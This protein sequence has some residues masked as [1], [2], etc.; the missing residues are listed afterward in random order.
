MRLKL[1]N[2]TSSINMGKKIKIQ[3]NLVLVFANV[4]ADVPLTLPSLSDIFTKYLVSRN[5]KSSIF[6]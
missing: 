2:G 1:N 4:N 6:S 3:L 5:E